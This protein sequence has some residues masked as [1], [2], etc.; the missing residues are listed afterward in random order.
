MLLN[1]A[2]NILLV[3]CDNFY[4]A[5]ERIF[6]IKLRNRPVL[7]LSSNDGIIVAR[8]P[9]S[10][11]LGIP[12]GVPKFQWNDVILKNNV[13][14]LSSNYEL[15]GDI[16]SRVMN[17]LKQHSSDVEVYSIDEAFLS[18]NANQ[19]D[20]NLQLATQI[21]KQINQWVGVS[22]TCGIGASKTLAKVA[23]EF[24]KKRPQYQGVLDLN[25]TEQPIEEFLEQLPVSDVWGVGRRYSDLLV[26]N[27]ISNAR[28][29]RDA[30]DAWIRRNLTVVGLRT[31]WEL[32]GLSCIPLE[33][34]PQPK[35]SLICSRSFGRAINSLSD[36]KEAIATHTERAA[37]KL[38]RQQSIADTIQVFIETDRFKLQEPQYSNS[39]TL[40]MEQPT[41]YT[42]EL[43]ST[44]IAGLERIFEANF[45]YKRAGIMLLGICPEHQ[46]QQ[47]FWGRAYTER[48]KQAMAAVDAINARFGKGTIKLATA[49]LTQNQNWQP[50]CDIRSPRYT[51]RWDEMK[52]VRAI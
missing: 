52:I 15:Y 36:L 37:E 21:R 11:A 41:A 18:L 12:M 16:S 31:V 47:G 28:Q 13:I 22:V 38:R 39:I 23:V 35:K 25:T 17:I 34:S 46:M 24:A 10:K 14:T 48:D 51:T 50:R 33:Q 26:K 5:C 7:V 32:R 45:N 2:N 19:P 30:D 3:D 43:I 44:A 4:V 49:C 20:Q 9:E 29:L 6:A 42:P 27:K 1:E 40:K 8:S